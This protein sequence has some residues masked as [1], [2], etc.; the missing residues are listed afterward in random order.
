MPESTPTPSS[1]AVFLSY[2]S[3]DAEAA[4]RI[5]EAL[6]P[7]QVEVWFDQS[8]LTGGDAWD[9]KIRKQI[10]ECAL[11]VPIITPNTNARAEGYF[12]REWKQAVERTHDMADD[13][14]FLFPI[15]IGDVTDATARVPD[16]FREV[17]WT[18]LRPDET[19]AEV[20]AHIT[21]LLAG[22]AP[23]PAAREENEDDTNARRKRRK[24]DSRPVW[25]RYAW[26][27]IGLAFAV[28]F[29]FGKIWRG[30][31]ATVPDDSGTLA[32]SAVSAVP[33]PKSSPAREL[34]KRAEALFDS[35][36]DASST[37][38]GAAAAL[39]EQAETL[40]PT[41][42]EIWALA[43]RIDSTIFWMRFDASDEQ[44]QRAQQAAAKAI[45]LAPDS[46]S[47]RRAQAVVYA[48]VVGTS[49]SIAEA[50]KIL[51]ELLRETPGD[52]GL[53][54]ELAAVLVRQGRVDEGVTLFEQ[55][56]D[57]VEEGWTYFA[58]GRFAEANKVADRMLV[59][60]RGAPALYLKAH[61]QLYGFEDPAAA[62]QTIGELPL[63]DAQT[64]NGSSIILFVAYCLRDPEQMLRAMEAF[65]QN[66]LSK[67]GFYGPKRMWTGV[68][69]EMAGHR[70]AAEAEWTVAL[71]QVMDRL[72]E[73]PGDLDLLFSEAL[74]QA[75]LGQPE[76]AEK[77]YRL[78]LNLAGSGAADRMNFLNS[79]ILLRLGRKEEAFASLSDG[80]KGKHPGWKIVHACVRLCPV[81]DPLRGD[82]RFEKL[83]RD[84]RP[85]DAKPFG[86]PKSE[87]NL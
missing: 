67:Q 86:D 83:L 30:P 48:G 21:R 38:L 57:L 84:T 6:R 79:W 65:P 77:T 28:Y 29:L 51:R 14:P 12:R 66:F 62:Q 74:L 45:A 78:Y 54:S 40:D 47:S 9:A 10:K 81:F 32:A 53:S 19:P 23:L 15:I 39:C 2:A 80:L 82:P 16:K 59:R 7:A 52:K 17:Q 73:R 27:V 71:Q 75:Q 69:Q 64:E 1:R 46:P 49:E 60:D 63:S 72:K 70:E 35:P 55:A 8:E 11:F 50:E 58:T 20:A 4:R 37:N 24:K 3:Q 36:V 61:V 34:A 76:T 87:E 18:R 22:G 44:R 26:S 85:P 25:L 56:G 13:V 43:A 5:A 41:D 31:R 42:A 68:A 33:V